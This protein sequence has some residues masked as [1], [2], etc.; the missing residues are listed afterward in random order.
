MLMSMFPSNTA[1]QKAMSAYKRKLPPLSTNVE[2]AES[3]QFDAVED[4]HHSI[5]HRKQILTVGR[6]PLIPARNSRLLALNQ[7]YLKGADG[8]YYLKDVG[9]ESSA[10]AANVEGG[11]EQA[12]DFQP[13][14]PAAA[15][16]PERIQVPSSHRERLPSEGTD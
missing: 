7:K 12:F 16:E 14:L 3:G 10:F 15:Q 9:V 4:Q 13:F 5:H 6:Q 11:P 1:I 2:V 8:R